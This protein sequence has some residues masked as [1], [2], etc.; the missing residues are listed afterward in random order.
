METCCESLVKH[1]IIYINIIFALFGLLSSSRPKNISSTDFRFK[2]K[3]ELSRFS[4]PRE[5]KFI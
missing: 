5:C 3:S 4:Q 1:L 2:M